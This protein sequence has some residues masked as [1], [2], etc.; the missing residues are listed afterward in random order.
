MKLLEYKAH[1]VFHEFEVPS[2]NGF[3][4]SSIEETV[5]PFIEGT[6]NS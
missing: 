1:E 6:S 2:I 5:K 4:V 3:T